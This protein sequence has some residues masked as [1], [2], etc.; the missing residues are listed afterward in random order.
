[1]SQVPL[2]SASVNNLSV[3]LSAAKSIAVARV[4]ISDPVS[5]NLRVDK[6]LEEYLKEER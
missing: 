3:E 6:A 5:F 2:S 4:S 1:M